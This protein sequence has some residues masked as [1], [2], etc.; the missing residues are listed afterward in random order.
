MNLHYTAHMEELNAAID[1]LMRG[2]DFIFSFDLTEYDKQYLHTRIRALMG[3][4]A[5]LEFN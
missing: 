3:P 2:E 4:E 5:E 1:T